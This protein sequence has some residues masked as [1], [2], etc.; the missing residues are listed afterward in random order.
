M[1]GDVDQGKRLAVEMFQSAPPH[2]GR[3]SWWRATGPHASF[4]PRPRMGGDQ[5]RSPSLR[6]RASFNPR[7]R[8]GGDRGHGCAGSRCRFQSAPPHGG[9]PDMMPVSFVVRCF[10]PRPRMGGDQRL[11][12]PRRYNSVSI[13]A[14]AWGAT[15][16]EIEANTRFVVSIRAPAWGATPGQFGP[17]SVKGGFNPRPRMGGD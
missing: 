17:G 9:R 1:G 2:G 7:P 14:P 15:A 16:V 12:D 10:N 4:N 6:L 11:S 8:M 13:R 3:P 5:R